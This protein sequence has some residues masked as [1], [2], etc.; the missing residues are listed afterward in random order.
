MSPALESE[1]FG[2]K[3]GFQTLYQVDWPKFN[4][5]CSSASTEPIDKDNTGQRLYAG[6]H[7]AIRFTLFAPIDNLLHSNNIVELGCGTGCFGLITA[8]NSDVKSLLLT[9]GTDNT[10]SIAHMNKRHLLPDSKN[11]IIQKLTWG[12][13]EQVSRVIKEYNGDL[14]YDVVI[15]CELMYYL[16]D[17][18]LLLSTALQLTNYQGLFIHAHLF[19]RAGQEDELIEYLRDVGWNTL[20]VLIRDFIPIEELS[21]HPAWYNMRALISG[22]QDR[23]A[24]LLAENPSWIVFQPTPPANSHDNDEE[25]EEGALHSLFT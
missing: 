23:I 24:S 16:T 14:P 25:L 17:I 20:E 22:P 12:D 3:V 4:Q 9:D 2:K 18:P 7:V 1:Y 6:A 15:G 11:V 13:S 19:R 21:Q 10:L 8:L 5:L